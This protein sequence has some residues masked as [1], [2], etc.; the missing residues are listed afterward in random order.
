VIRFWKRRP[1]NPDVQ[2]D[3]AEAREIREQVQQQWPAV[4]EGL[5]FLGARHRQN[6]FGDKLQLTWQ[7]K[8]KGA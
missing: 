2:A 3:I 7:P 4:L 6:G 1:P 5:A 8:R